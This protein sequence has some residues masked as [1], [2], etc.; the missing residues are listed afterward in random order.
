MNH[1]TI[2]ALVLLAASISLFTLAPSVTSHLQNDSDVDVHNSFS[3]WLTIN[4]KHYSTNEKV[5][6]L[7]KYKANYKFVK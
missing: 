1:K 6:R 4:R 5:F 3:A 2:L 7:N